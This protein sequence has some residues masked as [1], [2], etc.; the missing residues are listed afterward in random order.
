M[1]EN[2]SNR[3][4]KRCKLP[5]FSVHILMDVCTYLFLYYIGPWIWKYD[6]DFNSS[7][8][9]V[10]TQIMAHLIEWSG[11]NNI[12]LSSFSSKGQMD[13]YD[14]ITEMNLSDIGCR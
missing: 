7:R 12:L 10:Q 3:H 14:V 8:S 9:Q 11:N 6:V 2:L 5:P 1:V 13:F 4:L